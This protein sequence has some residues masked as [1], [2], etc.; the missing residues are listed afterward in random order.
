MIK[1]LLVFMFLICICQTSFAE[2][3]RFFVIN[4]FDGGLN[5]HSNTMNTPNNQCTE[6]SNIRINDEFASLSKRD[7]TSILWDSGS[8]SVN[9]LH[10]YYKANGT[11]QTLIATSTYLD[12]GSSSDTSTTHISSGLSDGA[13]WQFVTFKDIAIGTNGTDRPIKYDGHTQTTANTDGS[14]SSGELCADIGAPFAEINTGSNL[15]ASSWYQY[16]MMFL[17]SGVTYYSDARSNPLQTGSSVRDITLTNIPIGPAG[18]TARYLYR[19][20]GNSSKSGVEADTSFYLVTTISDNTTTTYDDTMTDATLTT[21]TAWDTSGKTECTPPKGKYITLHKERIWISGNTDYP[22]EIYYSDDGNPD[23][24]DPTDY[25]NVRPDDGDKISFAKTLLGTL[26]VGKSNSIQKI[27]TDGTDTTDWYVSERVETVGC[28]APYTVDICSKGLIYLSRHGIY[29]F[30]GGQSQLISDAV[31]DIINGI[32][33]LSINDCAGVYTNNEYRLAYTSES[34]GGDINDKVLIYD[35]VRDAYVLDTMNV[36]C[37]EVFESENDTGSLC[38]GS[39]DDDGYVLSTESTVSTITKRT[40][41]DFDDGTYDDTKSYYASS[42]SNITSEGLVIIEQAW[43]CTIDGWLTEL[44]SKNASISTIDDI[45]T[46]LPDATI[47]RPDKDG[48][49]TSPVYYIGADSLDN[50]KWHEN[51]GENGDITCQVRLDSDSNMTGISW[52]TAV[53]DP[54]GSSLSGIT[55]NDYIQ[56]RF[57][58]STTDSTYTPYFYETEGYVFKLYYNKTGSTN[59]T[60]V[61]SLWRSGWLNLGV[62]GYKK[63]IKRVRVYYTGTSGNVLFN[64]RGD[65]GDIDKTFTIDLSISP[66]AD[67]DDAYTGDWGEK[68]YTFYP[69]VNSVT[70]PSLTSELFQFYIT[71]HGTTN[72]KIE[73]IQ[74]QYQVEEIY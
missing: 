22:S 51:L 46:Y 42:G 25:F 10:R 56:I 43:D 8:S 39:S 1:K 64:I 2:N 15:D 13:R 52:E 44:Q 60:S 70:E 66:T 63:L 28:P 23:F 72:W 71:E 49:W 55:A 47:D 21:Q 48:T 35:F 24:F 14:R 38:F 67:S 69:P 36:K 18:T 7:K 33:N 20:E 30:N 61:L 27:Y 53:S 68:V 50:I 12:L 31:T 16:K 5:S 29:I 73:K 41:D 58:L 62:E 59:E 6:C 45:N 57:N 26:T 34:G 9:G 40:K 3:D 4:S 65:D 11:M 17:V 74:V 37:W 19:T 32:E 54:N